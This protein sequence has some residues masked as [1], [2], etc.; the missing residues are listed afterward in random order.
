MAYRRSVRSIVLAAVAATFLA[1]AAFAADVVV[2]AAASLKNALDN[3]AADWAKQ[4]GDK[5]TI[6]YA[7][8]SALAKQIEQGAPADV[9]FSAD[10]DW[11]DY[12]A[13][14][15]LI[16]PATRKSLLGN[17]IVLVAQGPDA[18][19]I[20]IEKGFDLAGALQGGKLAMGSVESVPA[21]KYGKAA[22]ESLGVWDSVEGSVA[23]ADNVRAALQLVALGEAPLGIVYATDAHAEP[24]VSV[25]GTFPDDTHPPIVYPVAR[26]SSSTNDAAKSF[27]DYLATPAAHARFEAEGF[28][29]LD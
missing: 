12:L 29:I 20:V 17:E 22:L 23:Q 4:S 3:V 14:R 28:T 18:K 15:K 5:A 16:D 1:P 10:L 24:K 11:M 9:F 2:F 19:P 13:E 21:G 25:V 27:L 8:S 7:A 26:T 6:S